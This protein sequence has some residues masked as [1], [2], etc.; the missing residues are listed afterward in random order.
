[1]EKRVGEILGN[2]AGDESE[3]GRCE[4]KGGKRG[5]REDGAQTLHAMAVAGSGIVGV[6]GRVFVAAGVVIGFVLVVFMILIVFTFFI[7]SVIVRVLLFIVVII[8]KGF[9]FI[10]VIIVKGFTFIVSVI[11]KSFMTFIVVIIDKPLP[12]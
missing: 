5:W 4:K 1:M 10:V 2:P 12:S 11:A 3:R 9:T 7:V 6:V 8:A